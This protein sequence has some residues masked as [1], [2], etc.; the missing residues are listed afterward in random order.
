MKV[1]EV[2][3][4]KQTAL[5]KKTLSAGVSTVG[6]CWCERF[7]GDWRLLSVES[8]WS[9]LILCIWRLLSILLC[10]METQWCKLGE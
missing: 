2:T 8:S 5:H 10:C 7:A 1:I 6:T 9:R 3:D 4:F